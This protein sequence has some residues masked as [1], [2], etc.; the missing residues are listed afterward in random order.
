[1]IDINLIRNNKD[2]VKEN[3]KKKF[4]NQKLDLVDKVYDLDIE[5]RNVKKSLD[6]SRCEKNNLSDKIG[7]L[8]REGKK[9]EALSVKEEVKNYAD[10]IEN[11]N[12]KEITLGKEIKEIMM[13]IPNIIDDSVP[14]GEDDSKNVEI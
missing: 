3:I 6:D 7:Q 8:M 10:I 9:E 12:E 2:L 13:K 5:Y 11:L 4:Q 14:L 1:M